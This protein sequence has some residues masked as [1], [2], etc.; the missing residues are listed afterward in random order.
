[1]S[2]ISSQTSYEGLLEWP[3]S[4]Q[5]TNSQFILQLSHLLYYQCILCIDH[6]TSKRMLLNALAISVAMHLVVPGT[7]A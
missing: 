2:A 7:C 6:F 1:M 4:G 3:T 5:Q